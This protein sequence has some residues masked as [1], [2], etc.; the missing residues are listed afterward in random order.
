MNCVTGSPFPAAI[1]GNNSL[2]HL[3]SPMGRRK[4]GKVIPMRLTVLATAATLLL[5]QAAFAQ[6]SQP[7][8]DGNQAAGLEPEQS[9]AQVQQ[10]KVQRV[11]TAAGFT[12]IKIVTSSLLVQAKT[13]AGKPVMMIVDP[14]SLT[15]EILE[16]D[17]TTG[18]AGPN[19]N[20]DPAHR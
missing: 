1:S 13:P 8:S 2:T 17:S 6:K 12:D 11:L 14:N 5:A 20:S 15:A 3:F 9:T 16:P 10:A 7:P 19:Q 18:S 4:A